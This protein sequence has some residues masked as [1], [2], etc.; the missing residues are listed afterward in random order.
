MLDADRTK[1]SDRNGTGLF[2]SFQFADAQNADFSF[3]AEDGCCNVRQTVTSKYGSFE[4]TLG[5]FAL[6]MNFA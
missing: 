6:R 5:L 2:E 3:A 1:C 4:E